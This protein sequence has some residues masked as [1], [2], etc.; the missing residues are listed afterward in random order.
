MRHTRHLRSV[1][2]GL[3]AGSA[4]LT[5]CYHSTQLAATWRDPGVN[6]LNFRRPVTVFVTKSETLRR[7]MEDKM[8]EQFPHATPSY[9][10]LPTS[11]LEDGAK[12]REILSDKGYDGAIVMRVASVNDRVTYTPGSYWYGPPY[13]SFAGYWGN[14]W[15]Y[16]YD[17]GYISTDVVVSIETQI[18]SLTR[19]KLVWAA[20]SETTDPKSV[21]RLGDS[22]IKHVMNELNKEGLINAEYLGSTDTAKKPCSGTDTFARP[23]RAAA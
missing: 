13:Y 10:V 19:D 1:A 9:R 3:L 2:I 17:P 7:T 6:T 8:A 20:R 23:I 11:H 14:A 22:V 15:G 12:V 21:G 5:G 16:P 18:Y 4:A